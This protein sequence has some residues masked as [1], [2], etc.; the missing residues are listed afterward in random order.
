VDLSREKI[1]NCPVYDPSKDIDREYEEQLYE[2]Y[3][4]PKYW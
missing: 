1:K 2:Y 3:G 4:R